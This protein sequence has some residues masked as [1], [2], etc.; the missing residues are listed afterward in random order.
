M[1]PGALLRVNRRA[2][3]ALLFSLLD[4]AFDRRGGDDRLG[5][6]F[7]SGKGESLSTSAPCG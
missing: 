2:F 3:V 4:H 6:H 5:Q 1:K 7:N